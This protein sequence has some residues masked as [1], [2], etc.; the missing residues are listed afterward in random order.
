M[1]F[2]IEVKVMMR[3][4]Q[5]CVCSLAGHVRILLVDIALEAVVVMV[6]AAVEICYISDPRRR[7]VS[8]SGA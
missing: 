7:S 4:R 5:N 8:S 1:V 6:V 3:G 2:V